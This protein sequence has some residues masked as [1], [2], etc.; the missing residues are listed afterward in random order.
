M[1]SMTARKE[2]INVDF[3]LMRL[4]VFA[5]IAWPLTSGFPSVPLI[6]MKIRPKIDESF[7]DSLAKSSMEFASSDEMNT[8]ELRATCVSRVPRPPL[9]EIFRDN[10]N[11]FNVLERQFALHGFSWWYFDTLSALLLLRSLV[12]IYAHVFLPSSTLSRVLA[13]AVVCES[14]SLFVSWCSLWITLSPA[15]PFRRLSAFKRTAT[16][17]QFNNGKGTR[18]NYRTNRWPTGE[19]G[20]R[21]RREMWALR[22][23]YLI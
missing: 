20:E 9:R 13:D 15:L 17:K 10:F 19:A 8:E 3:P 11:N 14:H 21:R 16:W 1:P 12:K 18:E 4:N 7:A 5:E 23:H 22:I 2:S 6:E